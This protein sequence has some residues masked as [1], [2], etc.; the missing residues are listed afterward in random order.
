ME[1]FFNIASLLEFQLKDYK[2]AIFYYTQYQATW[3]SYQDALTGQANPDPEQLQ[4]IE[5]KIN[6][7]KNHIDELKAANN[8]N[9]TDKIWNN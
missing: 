7:L 9:Y 6:E 8:V 5:L 4:E 1:L 3:L 2:Q